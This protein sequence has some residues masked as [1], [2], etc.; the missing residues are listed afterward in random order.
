MEDDP[1]FSTDTKP[2]SIKPMLLDCYMELIAYTGYLLKEVEKGSPDY[3]SVAETYQVL[4]DRSRQC[5]TSIEFTEDDWMEGFFPV[6][7]YIDETLL[8]SD[9]DERSKWERS[10]FQRQYFNTTSAGGEFF[11]R[12]ENLDDSASNLREVYE[13]CLTLGFKGRYYQASDIGRLEDIQYTHLKRVTD[14]VDLVY[15]EA[16][17]PD[18]YESDKTAKKRKRKKWKQLSLFSPTAFLLPTFLFVALYYFFD[19]FLTEMVS[20]YFGAGF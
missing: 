10:Q 16:L 19:R 5:A 12:L 3:D 6:S 8:C 20:R 15:P 1:V 2:F 14:N 7:A 11:N 17:F 9:W 18:A 4:V 13:F